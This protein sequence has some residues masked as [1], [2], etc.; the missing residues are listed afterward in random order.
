L[1]EPGSTG[2]NPP[3][4]G[5]P[6]DQ[7]IH[8]P[9]QVAEFLGL[10]PARAAYFS[11][12]YHRIRRALLEVERKRAQVT[13]D[14]GTIRVLIPPYPEE[15]RK[16]SED[17]TRHL[18]TALTPEERSR[19]DRLNMHRVLFA[20]DFG[21]STRRIE[22]RADEES[23]PFVLDERWDCFERGLINMQGSRGGLRSA[24][25]AYEKIFE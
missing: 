25:E 17:W 24:E 21:I 23:G 13:E 3:P 10:E 9:E 1:T 22:I 19:Y 6:L 2:A 7:V 11:Q 8:S 15:G 14:G 4:A 16:I 20:R 5:V 12:E 18:A